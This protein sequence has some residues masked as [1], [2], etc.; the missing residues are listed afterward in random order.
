M[1]N[2]ELEKQA[3]MKELVKYAADLYIMQDKNSYEVKQALM[4][5]GMSEESALSLIEALDDKIEK[6][7]NGAHN[8]NILIGGLIFFAGLVATFAHLGYVFWGAIVFGG[9]QFF[10]GIFRV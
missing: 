7:E 5:K 1:D 2:N 3:I 9:I 10:R 8:N 6:S 4:E